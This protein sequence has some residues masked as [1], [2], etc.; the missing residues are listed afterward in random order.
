MSDNKEKTET[1]DELY[2][3]VQ[4][5]HNYVEIYYYQQVKDI[6]A[7]TAIAMLRDNVPP[8]DVKTCINDWMNFRLFLS[9]TVCRKMTGR[10]GSR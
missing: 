8:A 9:R 4:D 6:A 5:I 1:I 10:V 2:G 7:V 3:S